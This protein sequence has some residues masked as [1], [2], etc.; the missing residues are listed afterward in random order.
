MARRVR[1]SAIGPCAPRTKAV[2]REGGGEFA[3][4]LTARAF[5]YNSP[6]HRRDFFMPPTE[7]GRTEFVATAEAAFIAGVPMRNIHRAVDED[8]LP[9]PCILA[10]ESRRIARLG[11]A[12]VGFYFRT[13]DVF[14]A[15]ARRTIIHALVER[16]RRRPD[17]TE[18]LAL[19]GDLPDAADWMV[20]ISRFD[21]DVRPYVLEAFARTRAVARAEELVVTEPGTLGGTPV[22]AGTRVPIEMVLASIDAGIDRNRLRKSYPFLTDE[23]VEAARTYS[24]VHPRRG[25]PPTLSERHPDLVSKRRTVL[26]G[27]RRA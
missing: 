15:E 11:A 22:F 2:A 21:V 12:L 7:L 20:S 16:F 14:V 24:A 27:A 19:A 9:E 26:R 5:G 13:E 23:H 1:T 6:I 18:L 8:I 3:S 4:L 17:W 10:A 25:R